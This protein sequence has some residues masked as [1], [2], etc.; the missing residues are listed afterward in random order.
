MTPHF[1]RLFVWHVVRYVRRHRLLALLN[2]LSVALGIAVWLAIQI[3]NR[4]A[5]ESF[6][7]GVD[8]VAGRAHLEVRGDL[9]ETLWPEIARAP[10]VNAAT[11]VVE[12]VVTLPDL[13]GE[14]LKVIGV[15]IFTSE[16]FRTYEIGS[17]D[18]RLDMDAWLG[19][20]ATLALPAEFATQHGLKVGDRLRVSANAAICDARIVALIAE[21]DVPSRLAVLD[22][23]WAQ[24][25]LGRVGHLSSIQLRLDDPRRAPEI[26]E[27]LRA[28]LPADLRIGAPRQRSFQMQTMLS[29]F[30]LNLTAMSMVSLLVGAFLIYNTISASVAR[31][32]VEIGILRALGATR[33]EVRC[34]FLG[35]AALFGVLG[36]AL[37][38]VG[39][40]ALARGMIGAVE[41]TV[42]SLYLLVSIEREFVSG[43]QLVGAVGFGFAAVLA[44]AWFPATEAS[45]IDPVATLSLGAHEE[46]GVQAARGWPAWALACLA[47]AAGLGSLALH[48]GPPP[49]AFGGA[50]FVLAGFAFLAPA[51]TST[52]GAGAARCVRFGALWRIAA[53]RL[54][55][56]LHRNAVT[57]AALATAIA[58]AV[59]LTVMIHSF[60]ESVNTWIERGIVADLFVAPAANE[61][62]GLSAIVPPA[63]IAWLRARPEVDSV[64]TFRELPVNVAGDP[65]Q[66]A[67]LAVV[68]GRYRGNL[69]FVGGDDAARMARVFAGEAVVVT[70]SFARKYRVQAGD[71]LPL[72]TPH[73]AVKFAVA[74]VYADYTRDQGVIFME[75]ALF[76][77]H[78]PDAG[79]VSLAVY[80]HPGADAATLAEAFR[81]EFSRAGEFVTYSNR[82]IRARI[83]KIFDQTFAVTYVLRT[84]AIIVAVLGIFLSVTTLVAERRR[85]TA[86]LRALGASRGQVQSIYISESAMIG[87]AATVLGLTA[88]LALAMVLTWVVNPAFFG[89]TIH[90]QM[91]WAALIAT[92]LWI[93]PATIA[94]A[95]WPARQAGGDLIAES[96][97]EE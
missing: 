17:P 44:G 10:G 7:A 28:R 46:R 12:G 13:P 81:A 92:P 68:E 49:L 96:V 74:G 29:A 35:E 82:A 94:A 26:A 78:W 36:I 59:G 95:W 63:T 60:R 31:R 27:A 25:L 38:I 30:Q 77:R 55:R 40:F 69:Q 4:S 51:A 21:K 67:L 83:F 54:R 86:M 79:P 3:A 43:W 45:H 24:E 89:W 52:L 14:Y 9:D 65:P 23:G 88:G 22:L 34:L 93:I 70:E 57:V 33:L 73:G 56:S 18:H 8:L 16:P 32:R 85:E 48:T 39:G 2:V 53:D 41:R 75:Q 58:M 15:D 19:Q 84:I 42:S 97:R 47:I 61:I 37:G 71:P 72:L 90:L 5:N 76:A 11:A 50:F 64:D 62:V 80:L 66:P 87:V 6:S 91:P 20:R 1:P